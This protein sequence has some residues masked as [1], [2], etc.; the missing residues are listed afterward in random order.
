MVFLLCF[1]CVFVVFLLCFCCVF[2]V[3]LLC[4]CFVF[5]VFFV[6]LGVFVGYCWGYCSFV[7]GHDL[8]I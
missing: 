3:F 2:V 1:C 8:R 5:V 4:F 6:V 7:I